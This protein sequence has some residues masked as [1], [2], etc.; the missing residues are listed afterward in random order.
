MISFT[1][2][3]ESIY[4]IRETSKQK[5]TMERI[6]NFLK[7][8]SQYRDLPDAVLEEELNALFNI[9]VLFK[10]DKNSLLIGNLANT[11]T[12]DQEHEYI[13]LTTSETSK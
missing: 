1:D 10:N 11:P 13:V 4:H 6:L 9:G 8:K 7:K 12:K 5:A 3:T 2:I